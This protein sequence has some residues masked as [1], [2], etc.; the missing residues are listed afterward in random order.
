MLEHIQKRGQATR[1]LLAAI[2]GVIALSMLITLLPGSATAPSASP[3]VV[4]E[5]GGQPI[6]ATDVRR[7]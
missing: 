1:I 6:T 5:V 7:P 3:D 2:I 4:V